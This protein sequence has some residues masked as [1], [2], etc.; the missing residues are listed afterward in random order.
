LASLHGGEA[1]LNVSLRGP[2]GCSTSGH[3]PLHDGN[4][5]VTPVL[6]LDASQCN[7]FSGSALEATIEVVNTST[8]LPTSSLGRSTVDVHIVDAD[9]RWPV[10]IVDPCWVF[11]VC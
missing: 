11:G 7:G 3:V 10:V 4:D 1:A 6:T 8:A 5:E 2:S 9:V